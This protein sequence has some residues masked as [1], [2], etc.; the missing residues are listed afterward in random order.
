MEWRP[1]PAMLF[2]N[3]GDPAEFGLV[4]PFSWRHGAAHGQGYVVFRGA[5]GRVEPVGLTLGDPGTAGSVIPN[6]PQPRV[7]TSILRVLPLGAIIA[8]GTRQAVALRD[9]VLVAQ[10]SLVAPGLSPAEVAEAQEAGAALLHTRGG[11]MMSQADA[12]S[13]LAALAASVR[14]F[15][16]GSGIARSGPTPRPDSFYR[17]VA[18]VYLRFDYPGGNPVQAIREMYRKARGV[19]VPRST[20]SRWVR[21]AQKKG[22]LG[23]APG[24]GR[25]GRVQGHSSEGDA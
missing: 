16:I 10:S 24:P 3:P 21:R 20:A 23:A 5:R 13:W 12:T 17:T 2:G 15:Q 7:T 22:F 9:A 18:D 6:E 25:I 19:L 8:E 11:T 14:E 1:K 4:F